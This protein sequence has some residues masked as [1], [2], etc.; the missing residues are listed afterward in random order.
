MTQ[1]RGVLLNDPTS[2]C[3]AIAK[4]NKTSAPKPQIAQINGLSQLMA[5]AKKGTAWVTE[6]VTPSRQRRQ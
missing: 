4:M 2:Q 5:E 6:T 1:G 3:P